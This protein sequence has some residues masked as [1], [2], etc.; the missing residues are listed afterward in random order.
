MKFYKADA[1]VRFFT[2]GAA[3]L[4]RLFF[5]SFVFVILSTENSEYC[6]IVGAAYVYGIIF[7]GISHEVVKTD[8]TLSS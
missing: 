8:E 6:K 3:R 7:S 1:S 2:Y 4:H 5:S